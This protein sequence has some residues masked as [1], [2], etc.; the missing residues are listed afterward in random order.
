VL[1]ARR[2]EIDNRVDRLRLEM[3]AAGRWAEL[4]YLLPQGHADAA[5]GRPAGITE[6]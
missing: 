6:Q 5:S 1:E 3:E 2:A 4:E